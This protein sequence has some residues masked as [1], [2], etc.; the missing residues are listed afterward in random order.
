MQTRKTFVLSI[1]SV[2]ILLACS[3][4]SEPINNEKDKVI[5]SP[6]PK[7]TVSAFSP[8]K[9]DLGDTISIKGKNFSR[10]FELLMNDDFRLQVVFSN[11]TVI[12][13]KVPYQNFN[14]DNFKIT[15]NDLD[16]EIKIYENP[17]ELYEP[18]VDSVSSKIGFRDKAVIYGKHLT[19]PPNQ[20]WNIVSINN[21]MV[22]AEFQSK[23]SIVV[24]LRFLYL[25]SHENDLLIQAQLQEI[26]LENGL[27]IAPPEIHG[28]NKSRIKVGDTLE[29]YG[30]YLL[31]GSL[32]NKVFIDGNRAKVFEA[33][34]DTLWVEMPIGP[35]QDR[36]ISDLNVKV[37]SKEVSLGIDLH[38]E[39][40]WYLNDVLRKKEVTDSPYA[41]NISKFSFQENG[42]FFINSVVPGD[43]HT[44]FNTRLLRYDPQTQV[45]TNLPEIPVNNDLSGNG[46]QLFPIQNGM[47]VFLYL[48]RSENNFF[49][50]N[51]TSGELTPLKDF[52]GPEINDGTGVILNDKFYFG[53]GHTGSMTVTANREMYE[54]DISNDLWTLHSEM[55]FES[56]HAYNSRKSDFT[57]NNS[58]YTGNGGERQYDFWKFTPIEGWTK[59]KSIPDPVSSYA[60]FQTNDKA[61][62]FH[63]HDNAFWEYERFSDSWSK[64]T[65]LALGRYFF[66]PE[67]AFIINEYVYLFG[68]YTDYSYEGSSVIRDDYIILRTEISNL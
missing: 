6:D 61:F 17:F 2:F 4:E 28:V 56:E 9:V 46:L 20:T 62:Y 33:F 1:L 47:D 39:N 10:G 44:F 27:K 15:L 60:H 11:D 67:A 8:Q 23:D 25:T 45:L 68:A 43:N 36:D 50:Y 59:K 22:G 14:P 54:Y 18:Q 65:D 16:S 41:G 26:N 19:N 51:Y 40:T 3:K 66:S 42:E 49:R 29:V 63:Q 35:Y 55:P 34:S 30:K 48:P 32:A 53:L 64:R 5:D 37:Y 58:L 12:M 13:F 52:P 38:L 24:D 57:W 7:L 31:D 21:K